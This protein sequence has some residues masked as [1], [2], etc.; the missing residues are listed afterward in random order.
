MDMAM[1]KRAMLALESLGSVVITDEE[2]RYVYVSPQ[3]LR[4]SN[5]TLKEMVGKY[6]HDLFVTGQDI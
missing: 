3:R 5:F 1:A 6:V 2:G 4:R